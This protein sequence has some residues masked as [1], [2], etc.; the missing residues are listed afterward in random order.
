MNAAYTLTSAEKQYSIERYSPSA[1]GSTCLYRLGP[2]EFCSPPPVSPRIA[3]TEPIRDQLQATLGQ[4]YRIERELGG[5]GMSRV[6]I[7]EETAFGRQVVVKVLPPELMEGVS[8]ER[9]NREILLAAKLQHPHIVPVL[10]AG[11]TQGLPYYTMPLAE[12]EGRVP[13]RS[14]LSCRRA[15]HHGGRQCVA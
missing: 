4:A 11:E 2:S 3:L 10:T 13:A 6:F 5:G 15:V 9:F 8:V 7:A 14:A 12:G 1:A